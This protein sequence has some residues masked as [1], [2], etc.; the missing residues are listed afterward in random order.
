MTSVCDLGTVIR[1]L[2]VFGGPYSNLAAT[3][4][5]LEIASARGFTGGNIICTGDVVA[6][7]AHPVETVRTVRDA[8]IHVVMGNCEESLGE[9]L[10]DCGCGFEEGS[11]CDV[12]SRSWFTFAQARIDDETRAWMR[13]LPRLIKGAIAGRRFAVVHGHAE[14]IS[15]WVFASTAAA[16]KT[17]QLEKLDVDIVIGGHCGLPFIDPLDDGRLWLN[18][19]VVGMPAND[20]TPR[21][22]YATLTPGDEGNLDI[23]IESFEYDPSPEIEAMT[24]FGLPDGYRDALSSGLWP[25]MDV[26]PTAERRLRG[27]AIAQSH[28]TLKSADVAAA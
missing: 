26:L 13:A 27:N 16:D 10:D 1:P 9:N 17:R 19:G 24:R 11:A 25:N 12:L 23:R 3:E 8:G 2:F 20:G 7:C 15:G 18:A 21:G 6:Y 22:W 4:H 14:D 5:V 28:L